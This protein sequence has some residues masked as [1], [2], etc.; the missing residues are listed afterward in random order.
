MSKLSLNHTGI[1]GPHIF[2]TT[3][4]RTALVLAL[5]AIPVQGKEVLLPAFTCPVAVVGSILESG[6]TPI[7]VDIEI[8]SLNFDI[9]D[10][11]SKIT[12]KSV[13]LISHHYFGMVNRKIAINQAIASNN[14]LV[15]IEDCA[16]VMGARHNDVPAGRNC[17]LA[18]YSFSKSLIC[19]GG[20]VLVCNTEGSLME[21]I[22]T[23]YKKSRSAFVTGL[24][25]NMELLHYMYQLTIIHRYIERP[26]HHVNAKLLLHYVPY[27]WHVPGKLIKILT[28]TNYYH[29]DFYQPSRSN[30][31]REYDLR[32]TAFQRRAIK[33]SLKSF[34][35]TIRRNR[36]IAQQLGKE[37]PTLYQE[38]GDFF[39]Y[40]C[41]VLCTDDKTLLLSRAQ[42]SNIHLNE[43]WPSEGMYVSEQK[44]ERVGW[45]E[46][47]LLLLPISPFFSRYESEQIESFLLRNKDLMRS[48][49]P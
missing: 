19:P 13:A 23:I 12:D 32:M 39:T 9:A 33:R 6:G 49:L 20:G 24:L 47:H 1:A 3:Y 35:E 44:T 18:V 41:L 22:S 10:L 40:P 4:A 45:I 25:T 37:I 43:T 29:G 15:H 30:C 42:E 8:D 17:D 38:E 28:R 5:K 14:N 26:S 46:E 31:N 36:E 27:L 7:F 21:R 48:S 34:N 11:L 16:H 2:A